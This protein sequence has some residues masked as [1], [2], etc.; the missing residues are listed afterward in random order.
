MN[1]TLAI[2]TESHVKVLNTSFI[3]MLFFNQ[4]AN[5][6]NYKFFHSLHKVKTISP[7]QIIWIRMSKT[8]SI[9]ADSTYSAGILIIGYA[10]MSRAHYQGEGSI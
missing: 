10:L 3:H 1:K 5:N 4:L 6:N 2:L 7:V 8:N 9:S